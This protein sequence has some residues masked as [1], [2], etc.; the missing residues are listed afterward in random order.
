MILPCLSV[1]LTWQVCWSKLV[2]ITSYRQYLIVCSLL[3][4][5]LLMMYWLLWNLRE[6]TPSSISHYS[7]TPLSPEIV[8]LVMS[9][10]LWLIVVQWS[11]R[12][13]SLHVLLRSL[14]LLRYMCH[15]KILIS[16]SQH[17]MTM[18]ILLQLRDTDVVSGED[19][20]IDATLT[21]YYATTS[22]SIISS[23]VNYGRG[24]VRE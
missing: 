23:R 13:Y 20:N 14:S 16:H 10:T 19:I 18:A 22:P 15:N 3:P 24:Q 4:V 6:V 1:L 5:L 12:T 7:T 2:S 8:Q 11:Y 17:C 21:E 9:S